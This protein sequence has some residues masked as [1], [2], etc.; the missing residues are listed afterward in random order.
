[1]AGTSLI[2]FIEYL[3]DKY[4]FP[5]QYPTLALFALVGILPSVIILSYFHGAPGKDEWTKVEQIGI[6][7]NVLFI[8]VILFFGDSLHIWEAHKD[9]GIPITKKELDAEKTR[10]LVP[11]LGSR[12]EVAKL[13]NQD[14]LK[15]YLIRK[16]GKGSENPSDLT[17]TPFNLEEQKQLYSE[18][19]TKINT[20]FFPENI[21]Y[22]SEDIDRA[23][24]KKAQMPPDFTTF[25]TTIEKQ[26]LPDSIK[27]VLFEPF[28]YYLADTLNKIIKIVDDNEYANQLILIINGFNIT[29]PL[30]YIEKVAYIDVLFKKVYD[31]SRNDKD[32]FDKSIKKNSTF[33]GIHSNQERFIPDIIDLIHKLIQKYSFDE[34]IAEIESVNKNKIF[35]KMQLD[36]PLLKNTELKVMRK[37]IYQDSTSIQNKMSHISAF[38]ECCNNNPDDKDCLNSHAVDWWDQSEYD[39]LINN[40]HH[41]QLGQGSQQIGLNKIILIDEVYDSIAVGKV[42][43]NPNT[44][45]KLL[46][47]DLLKL[48]K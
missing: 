7:I 15:S 19:I 47:G 28:N 11:H 40:E 16:Y 35:I 30:G 10:I 39:K 42:I 48:N 29:P 32:S 17:V 25:P 34:F 3:V 23:F 5:S 14:E 43:E 1:M 4:Q 41:L 12:N 36:R 21:I 26:L 8:A 9:L 13:I 6:P 2:L 44:C 46:P 18:L 31:I 27:Q 38:M 20:T 33:E 45:I 22:T 24:E 37:Y